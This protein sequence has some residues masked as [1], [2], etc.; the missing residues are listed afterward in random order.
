MAYHYQTKLRV[1]HI[2]EADWSLIQRFYVAHKLSNIAAKE[3]AVSPE[4]ASGRPGRSSIELATNRVLQYEIIR[5]QRLT[6][7]VMYND[8]TACYIVLSKTSA[9]YHYF[10]KAYT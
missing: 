10:G 2:Y 5:L 4:Q 7:A 1:I 8:A 6:A 9:T 3:K